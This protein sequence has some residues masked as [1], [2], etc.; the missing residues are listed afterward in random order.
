MEHLPIWSEEC[1]EVADP[2]MKWEHIKYKIH[3]FSA[4]YGKE[5][6]GTYMIKKYN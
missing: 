4:K 6:L 2:R 1:K 5:R 3:A